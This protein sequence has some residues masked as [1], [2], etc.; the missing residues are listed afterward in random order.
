M[1]TGPGAFAERLGIEFTDI[2]TGT[3]ECRLEVTDDHHNPNGVCHGGVLYSLADTGM[4]A[5][6][7]VALEDGEQ[8]ATIELKV[9]YL[10]PVRAGT[11]T[12]E[13]AVVKRGRS[14]AFLESAL[15][16]DG[17]PVALASGSFAVFEAERQT[18]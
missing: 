7:S 17:E 14:V 12:C 3:S 11:V 18:P 6:L 4:G 15:A 10:R 8:C 5:A 13:T 9:S 2:G 16:H 1:A